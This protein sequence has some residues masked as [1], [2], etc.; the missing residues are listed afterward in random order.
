MPTLEDVTTNLPHFDCE[1]KLIASMRKFLGSINATIELDE[2]GVAKP[3]R[4][5]DVHFM[6]VIRA[7][8]KF[9]TTEIKYINLYRMH[10]GVVFISCLTQANGQHIDQST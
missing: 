5:H 9:K 4:E 8:P 7:D 6:D 3:Q 1:S 2:A 10:V